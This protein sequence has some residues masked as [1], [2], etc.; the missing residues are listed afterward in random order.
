MN[1]KPNFRI[2]LIFLRDEILEKLITMIEVDPRK[3]YLLPISS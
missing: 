2:N 1:L 3:S